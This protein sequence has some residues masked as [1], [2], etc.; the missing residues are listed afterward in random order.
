ML[1]ELVFDPVLSI[2][3]KQKINLNV[4]SLTEGVYFLKIETQAGVS[5][6]K[7]IKE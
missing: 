1:G 7:F 2:D 5:I 4:S 3:I 6:Q